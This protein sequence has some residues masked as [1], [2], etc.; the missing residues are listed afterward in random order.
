MNAS[1]GSSQGPTK[2]NAE[3][4][5]AWLVQVARDLAV[6]AAALRIAT[7]L[8]CS[9]VNSTT[10]LAWPSLETLARVTGLRDS[11]T[12]EALKLLSDREHLAILHARGRGKVNR[13]RP[14][15][16]KTAA[17]AAVSGDE[18][19]AATAEKKTPLQRK[20]NR[21]YSG[22]RTYGIEPREENPLSRAARDEG[23]IPPVELSEK[24]RAARALPRLIKDKNG[25]E[26]EITH[27][28]ERFEY[29]FSLSPNQDARKMTW[30][31]YLSAIISGQTT[32]D[33]LDE[34]MKRYRTRGQTKW[35]RADRWIREKR[36][37]DPAPA[38][39]SQPAPT[40]PS[41]APINLAQ[42][43]RNLAR[44]TQRSE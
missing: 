7:T 18:K 5:D 20:E 10:W 13:Y 3:R 32:P 9:Y 4:K 27:L 35:S 21:R 23:E 24:E 39:D 11:T 19:T 40:R 42:K 6:T 22:D 44:L 29:F 25:D 31:V 30:V 36:Y 43:M 38:Y 28:R 37:D 1:K 33:E 16:R 12:R 41:S 15:L 8:A 14:M 17:A 2:F 34:G 26:Y